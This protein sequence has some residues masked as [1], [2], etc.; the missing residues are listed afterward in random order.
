MPRNQA[1]EASHVKVGVKHFFP[2]FH[3]MFSVALLAWH[4]GGW[5]TIS[6]MEHVLTISANSLQIGLL[7]TALQVGAVAGVTEQTVRL[8]LLTRMMVSAAFNVLNLWEADN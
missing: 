6:S 3:S 2:I 7:E 5:R 8:N 1:T 4:A